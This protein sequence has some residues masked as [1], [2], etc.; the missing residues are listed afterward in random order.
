MPA[1]GENLK[2]NG[3]RLWDSLMEMAK[4]GPWHRRWQQSPDPDRR[5]QRRSTPI[6]EM[7]RSDAGCSAWALDE[8]GNMFARP[9]RNGPASFAGLCR[10]AFGYA[11]DRRGKYDGVLGVLRVA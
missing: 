3:A 7:V 9:G 6:P 10:L 4:I 2:I 8:M 1:A 11:A 5:R